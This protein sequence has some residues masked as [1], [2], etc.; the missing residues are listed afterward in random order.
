MAVRTILGRVEESPHTS[1]PIMRFTGETV[2]TRRFRVAQGQAYR[3]LLL[4][5]C[6]SL[7]VRVYDPTN[8]SYFTE[9]DYRSLAAFMREWQ[10]LE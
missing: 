6:G 4:K 5:G 10:V 1:A 2:V 7:T 9:L 8:A 3:V